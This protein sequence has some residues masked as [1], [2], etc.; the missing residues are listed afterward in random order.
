[1]IRNFYPCIIS[2]LSSDHIVCWVPFVVCR[3]GGVTIDTN[4]EVCRSDEEF[5]EKLSGN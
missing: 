1:M 4:K 2:L 5:Y 3:F